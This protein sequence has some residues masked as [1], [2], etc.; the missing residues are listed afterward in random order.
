VTDHV[1]DRVLCADFGGGLRLVARKNDQA[2]DAADG[3]FRDFG[4]PYLTRGGTLI[5]GAVLNVETPSDAVQ[6][7]GGF[8]IHDGHSASLAVREG[9]SAPELGP[10]VTVQRLFIAPLSPHNTPRANAR[11][12]FLFEAELGGV[13]ASQNQALLLHSSSGLANVVQSGDQ[14]PGLPAGTVF[15]STN[16]F[17]ALADDGRVVFQAETS[18]GTALYRRDITGLHLVAA[19]GLQAPGAPSG[20]RIAELWP[21]ESNANA[22]VSFMATLRNAANQNVG[23]SLFATDP[24]GTPYLIAGVGTTVDLGGGSAAVTKVSFYSRDYGDVEYSQLNDAGQLVFKATLT[25]DRAGIFLA[26]VPEPGGALLSVALMGIWQ[27]RRRRNCA[28]S[29]YCRP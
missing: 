21:F 25:G 20:T 11:G 27:S 24:A 22:Q 1:D 3:R 9:Q 7:S 29:T 17:A 6:T 2:F 4:R 18:A 5:F 23:D 13:P 15:T 26:T 12:D 19:E 8:W 16:G 10:G 28:R 14:A